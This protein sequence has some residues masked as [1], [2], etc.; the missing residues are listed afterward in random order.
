MYE[1]EQIAE[2]ELTAD[3]LTDLAFGMFTIFAEQ[4]LEAEAF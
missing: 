2:D 1:D 4:H 3:E